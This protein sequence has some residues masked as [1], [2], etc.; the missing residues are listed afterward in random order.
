[1]KFFLG[2]QKKAIQDIEILLSATFLIVGRNKVMNPTSGTITAKNT[3][4]G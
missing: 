3:K 1:M 4:S 2:S